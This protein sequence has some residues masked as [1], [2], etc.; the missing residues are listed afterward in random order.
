MA[1]FAAVSM[2]QKKYNKV[3]S[4]ASKME[5]KMGGQGSAMLGGAEDDNGSYDTIS[6]RTSQKK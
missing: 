3:K 1:M 5:S 2:P 6:I 4:L